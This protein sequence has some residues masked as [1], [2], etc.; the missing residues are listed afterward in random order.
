MTKTA[1]PY[2]RSSPGAAGLLV[3]SLS[4]GMTLELNIERAL[5]MILR[6][7]YVLQ[8]ARRINRLL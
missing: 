4:T 5:S 8:I 6:V 1:R 7:P 2:E 3:G